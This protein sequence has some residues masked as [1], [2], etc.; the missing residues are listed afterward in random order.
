ML[1]KNKK[2]SLKDIVLISVLLLFFS[3]VLLFGY[4]INSEFNDQV[5]TMDEIP[6]VAKTASS[7]LNNN[8]SGSL[9][10][11]FLFLTFGLAMATLVLAALVRIHPIF[12]PFY[13]LGLIFVIILSAVFSNIYQEAAADPELASLANDF[14][15]IPLIMNALPFVVG[16]FGILLMIVMYKLWSVEQ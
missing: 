9:D 12:I 4:K 5:Q 15:F 13:F 2:G 14:T 16:V 7:T 3:M 10:N 8:F 1:R 11:G 6:A